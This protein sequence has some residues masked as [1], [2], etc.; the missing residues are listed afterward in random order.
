MSGTY[1][2][3]V[4]EVTID[5][6]R[7]IGTRSASWCARARCMRSRGVIGC[8][9]AWC[10]PSAGSAS[11]PCHSIARAAPRAVRSPATTASRRAGPGAATTTLAHLRHASP[12]S[13]HRRPFPRRA[14]SL[15]NAD[16]LHARVRG[17]AAGGPRSAGP[18]RPVPTRRPQSARRRQH[19]R[20]GA[21]PRRGSDPH[22][23]RLGEFVLPGA[24]T[25]TR[26]NGV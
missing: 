8:T 10:R 3:L 14:R 26:T 11:R 15:P 13:R 25:S 5:D 16:Q 21:G 18:G 22:L 7:S 12:R 23:G 6:P 17:S 9:P 20:A 24:T 4:I 2:A 19:V 1:A